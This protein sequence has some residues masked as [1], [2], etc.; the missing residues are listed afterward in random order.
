MRVIGRGRGWGFRLLNDGC[1][2]GHIRSYVRALD[3]HS[4]HVVTDLI[5]VALFF[6]W[7]LSFNE[8]D[9]RFET[10]YLISTKLT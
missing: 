7:F 9:V 1:S 8:R 6:P 5:Q 10:R 2:G 4:E 3:E